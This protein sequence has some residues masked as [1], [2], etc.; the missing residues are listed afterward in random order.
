MEDGRPRIGHRDL[1]AVEATGKIGHREIVVYADHG[2][3]S[4]PMPGGRGGHEG[5]NDGAMPEPVP[6]AWICGLSALGSEAAGRSR[7]RLGC[8][9]FR[10]TGRVPG[11]AEPRVG[12]LYGGAAP[13]PFTPYLNPYLMQ[14]SPGNPDYLTYMYLANQRNGGIG[15]GVIS[16]T[17]LR[18]AP[19]S[20]RAGRVDQAG[21]QALRLANAAPSTPRAVPRVRSVAAR[22]SEQNRVTFPMN[23]PIGPGANTGRLLHAAARTEGNGNGPPYFNRTTPARNNARR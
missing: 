13:T 8:C 7:R 17:R 22:R 3:G 4:D 6:L 12:R 11:P 10:P 16:G 1:L 2:W 14:M 18:V 21:G 23:S 5:D 15:T 20:G 19:A 9:P